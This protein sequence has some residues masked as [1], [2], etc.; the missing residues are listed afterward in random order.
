MKDQ[1]LFDTTIPSFPSFS[2]SRHSILCSELKQLYVAVTRTRQRLWICENTDVA[3]PIFDYWRKKFLVQ[4][5]QLDD[6]LAQ[7]MQVASSPEEWRSR[8]IKLYHEHNYEMATMC[9]ERA[10]DTYWERM[11]KAAGLKAMADRMRISSPEEANSVLREAAEIFEAIGK[12]DSA[13]RCF[14]DLGEYER[15]GRIYLEKFGESELQRA[16]ECFSLAGCYE[17]AADVYARGSYFSECLNACSKRKIFD[18]GLEYIQHWKK[19][20][21]KEFGTSNRSHELEKIEQVFL[22]SCAIHYH[23]IKDNRSMMTFVRAFNSI[24]SIRNF[25]RPLNCL[26]ELLMLEEESGNFMEA[27]N[28]AKLKGDTLLVV[29]LLEKAGKF[30]EAAKLILFYVLANSLWSPGNKG[31][32]LKQF[33]QKGEL[34]AKAKSFAEKDTNS[35]YEIVCSE[36]DI[37]ANEDCEVVKVMNQMIASRKH[38]SVRGEI[39]SARKILDSHLSSEFTKYFWEEELVIDLMKHS[40]DM[41]S[42]NQVSIDSLVYFWNFWKDKIGCIFEYLGRLDTQ[43]VNEFRNYGEFCLNFLGVWREFN[44]LNPIYVLLHPEAD[45]A[46]DVQKRSSSG[47]LVSLDTHQFVSAGQSYWRSEMLSVGSMVLEKLKGLYNFPIQKCDVIFSKSRTLTLIYE[48]ATFLLDSKFLKRSHHDSENLLKFVRLATKNIVGYIFPMDWRNSLRKNM[49]FQRGTDTSKNLLKQAIAESISS[50]NKLSYGQIGSIAMI[51][52]GSGKVSNE[53]YEK[54]VGG[55]DWNQS[56]KAFFESSFRA[57]GSDFREDFV[58]PR[59]GEKPSEASV[60]WSFREA[61]AETYNVNWRA[62]S[63]YISPRCFL[64]LVERLLIWTSSFKGYFVSTKSLFVEWLMF[65]EEHT[66]APPVSSSVG[67]SQASALEFLSRVI[68]EFLYNERGTTD[69]IRKSTSNVM[70]HYSLLVSRLVVLTCLLY[71]NFGSCIDLLV[72]LLKMN[73]ITGQLTREFCFALNRITKGYSPPINL[74]LIAEAVKKIDNPLV[75]ASKSSVGAAAAAAVEASSEGNQP[76]KASESDC[77]SPPK[78]SQA[79]TAASESPSFGVTSQNT[80][81]K[82]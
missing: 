28:I 30:K 21:T 45:W 47:K 82:K 53:V 29:D 5:R 43:D 63:H 66:S 44:N 46:R 74:N 62:V 69:W 78:V 17:L 34:L 24:D 75:I 40:E 25:L 64:Y 20:T 56:W 10:C 81:S 73:H 60:V 8:G 6:S 36:A 49:I 61:L 2:E 22:E 4:D 14:S 32:P 51:I 50:R 57:R 27:A 3:E 23:E 19:H 13:A 77:E 79:S 39:L 11:S 9:F 1:D 55:L 48:V 18:V 80:K 67:G 37:I 7:A 58:S 33:K 72:S 52:L 71:V 65:H 68:P 42:K 16:G 31:W 41:I 26:D 35:F 59:T 76:L 12:A 54:I 70:E 15:A 38:N